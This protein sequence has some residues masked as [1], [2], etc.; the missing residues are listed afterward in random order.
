MNEEE[1]GLIIDIPATEHRPT[2]LE[3]EDFSS[4]EVRAPAELSSAAIGAA[5]DGR[6]AGAEHVWI[7]AETLR[8]LAGD[9]DASWHGSFDAMLAKVEPHGWYDAGT[10]L[11][12]AH[13][14]RGG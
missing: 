12:K 5:L 4:L 7:P 2:L 6:E 11:V 8:R 1:V 9:V 14:V 10:G 3:L 13:V